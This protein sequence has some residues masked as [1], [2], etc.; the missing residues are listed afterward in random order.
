MSLAIFQ[1][2]MTV[3]KVG[4]KPVDYFLSDGD[5]QQPTKQSVFNFYRQG[6]LLELKWETLQ[7]QGIKGACRSLN[8]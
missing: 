5:V 4:K 8:L 6:R 2:Y 7:A 1:L 3:M